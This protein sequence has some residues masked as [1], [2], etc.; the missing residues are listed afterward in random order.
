MLTVDRNEQER[1]DHAGNKPHSRRR[2]VNEQRFDLVAL[3]GTRFNWEALQDPR[4]SYSEL[5]L[6]E[7]EDLR[8][9]FFD[10]FKHSTAAAGDAGQRIVGHNHR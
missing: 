10:H 1:E 5:S 4:L 9:V 3:H 6:F 7:R 8:P 2:S